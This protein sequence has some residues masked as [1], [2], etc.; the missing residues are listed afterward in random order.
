MQ[1]RNW[2]KRRRWIS[3]IVVAPIVISGI[4]AATGDNNKARARTAEVAHTT[5]STVTAAPRPKPKSAPKREPNPAST[6][7][8]KPAP[9]SKPYVRPSSFTIDVAASAAGSP[10]QVGGP[11][12]LPA[13]TVLTVNAER[14]FE[15]TQ[16]S[17]RIDFLGRDGPTHAN[18]SVHNGRFTA[19]FRRWSTA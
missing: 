8:P 11:T 7:K 6:P 3:G 1:W 14:A 12:N 19:S 17:E 9:K 18:V 10:V 13:G 5:S 2:S 4:G 16:E 15:Q